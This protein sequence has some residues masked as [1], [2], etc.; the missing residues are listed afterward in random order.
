VTGY[1]EVLKLGLNIYQQRINSI[2]VKE[3][4]MAKELDR[5]STGG[6]QN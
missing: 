6:L 1:Q 5:I 3:K 2:T 4:L